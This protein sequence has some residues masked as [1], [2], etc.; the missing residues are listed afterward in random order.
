MAWIRQLGYTCSN[1]DI[2]LASN[3]MELSYQRAEPLTWEI[4]SEAMDR[5]VQERQA[6]ATPLV[7]PTWFP[8]PLRPLAEQWAREHGWE[9]VVYG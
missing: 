3:K 6:S 2:D 4:Y 8:E 9:G 5:M 7:L 1:T